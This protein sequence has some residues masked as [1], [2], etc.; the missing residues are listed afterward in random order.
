MCR[1]D[2]KDWYETVVF[3]DRSLGTGCSARRHLAARHLARRHLAARSH[4]IT[5]FTGEEA[6]LHGRGLV[7]CSRRGGWRSI[8]ADGRGPISA[9]VVVSTKGGGL[10]GGL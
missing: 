1:L 9:V 3:S 2:I 6:G 8:T 4:C 10:G 7:E 5:E